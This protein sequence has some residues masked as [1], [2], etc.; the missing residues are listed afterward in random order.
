MSEV[1]QNKPSSSVEQV[2][3]FLLVILALVVLVFGA[4][5]LSDYFAKPQLVVQT[6]HSK[7]IA[8]SDEQCSLITEE[9]KKNQHPQHI[10]VTKEQCG[11][12]KIGQPVMLRC[13]VGVIGDPMK[14]QFVRGLNDQGSGS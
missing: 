7:L 4:C 9:D 3:V 12:I 5:E 2:R 10:G 11:Q 13:L 6:V 1:E 14:C 8:G